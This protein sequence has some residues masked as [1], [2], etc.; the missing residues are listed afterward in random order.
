MESYYALLQ[1]APTAESG[2]IE[3]AYRRLARTHH[4]DV[5]ASPQASARMRALN[6]AYETLSDPA[7]RVAYD[8]Q[9]ELASGR[10]RSSRP[11]AAVGKRAAGEHKSSS[12]QAATAS[13]GNEAAASFRRWAARWADC[14][15]AV[16]AGDGAGRR[17]AAEAGQRCLRELTDCLSRWE[18]L[19]P[20]RE[21]DRQSYLGAAC[22]RLELALVRGSIT[23]AENTDFSVLQPLAGLAERI[24]RLTRTVA[25]EASYARRAV[26]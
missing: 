8:R 10:Q 17:R 26:G 5:S 23:F 11:K 19:V 16:V 2:V 24:E 13:L 7:R 15:E 9:L 25:A 3:A 4:P 22:L 14:L 6:E 21:S 1:V 12:Y 18:A 20:P